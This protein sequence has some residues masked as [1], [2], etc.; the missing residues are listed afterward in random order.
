MHDIAIIR[1]ITE[2]VFYDF[3]KGLR[4]KS[5]VKIGYCLVD[6]FFGGGNSALHV[7]L[8]HGGKVNTFLAKWVNKGGKV[9]LLIGR[10]VLAAK[11]AKA[12]Q[13]AQFK[14]WA[15]VLVQSLLIWFKSP[16]LDLKSSQS[17]KCFLF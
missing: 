15:A 16:D 12:A 7:S 8:V 6:I 11:Y 10:M 13:R 2:G 9:E 5:F 14:S 4:E 17:S 3:A 1:I